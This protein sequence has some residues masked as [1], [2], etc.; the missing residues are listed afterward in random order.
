MKLSSTLVDAK[1]E[2]IKHG[3]EPSTNAEKQYAAWLADKEVPDSYA[4]AFET[5]SDFDKRVKVDALIM[6][7]CPDDV[8]TDLLSIPVEA[9]QVYRELF[10]D[11]SVLKTGID[12]LVF[13]E[14]YY[15]VYS[16]E[17]R[18]PVDN[19]VLRGYN[20]GYQ[21]LLLQFCSIAPSSADSI[22]ILRRVFAA[23]MYKATAVQYTGIGSLAD[24]RAMEHCQLAIKIL[25]TMQELKGSDEETG[26]NL[27][28]FVSVLK[29]SK[30][31]PEDFNIN[32]VVG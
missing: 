32:N 15:I 8:F 1:A 31:V 23:A 10:F 16:N 11:M 27:V 17:H 9:M 25:E 2:K 18:N 22:N 7:G 12:K 6:G 14:K 13:A 26:N 30:S 5:Y 4:T 3:G 19:L 28:R 20:Q 21:L 24:K 29:D